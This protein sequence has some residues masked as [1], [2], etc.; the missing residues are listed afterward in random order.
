MVD[1]DNTEAGVV[2]DLAR[3]AENKAAQV[4]VLAAEDGR[5]YMVKPQGVTVE[6]ITDPHGLKLAP[7]RYVSQRVT[8]QAQE[9]LTDYVN[10]F[11]D[12]STVLL[13]DIA[14]STIVGL[15]DYHAPSE[16]LNEAAA[17]AHTAHRATLTLPLSEQWRLWTSVDGKLMPQLEFARF[18]E[19]NAADVSS[20]VAAE[21]LEAVRDLQALRK[22]KFESAV[23]TAS[24]NVNVEYVD[25]TDVVRKDGLQL[26][27][28]FELQIPVYFEGESHGLGAFL[29][30][31][32]QD[33]GGLLI[34]LKLQRPEEVRQAVFKEV[35][36]A[37]GEATERPVLYGRLG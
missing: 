15:I 9:S 6:E 33:G 19:E 34:G 26:P 3:E 2:A 23:R 17:A 1:A 11:K 18:L 28:R 8:L 22:V 29:R 32:V 24:G 13:A 30:H 5:L 12:G 37:V 4:R 25:Q 20:P 14:T 31:Q 7:P 16:Q 35:V 36:R 21:V 10:R 27:N